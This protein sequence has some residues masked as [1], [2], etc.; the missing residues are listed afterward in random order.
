MGKQTNIS[1]QKTKK[2]PQTCILGM[3]LLLLLGQKPLCI[4]W[5]GKKGGKQTYKSQQKVKKVPKVAQFS[6]QKSKKS[7][8]ICGL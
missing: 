2:Y 6:D 8:Q 5:L 1:Q 7:P 4:W 3:D